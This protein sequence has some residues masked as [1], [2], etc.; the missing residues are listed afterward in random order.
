MIQLQQFAQ[1]LPV[2]TKGLTVTVADVLQGHTL[3]GISQLV[4]K[5]FNTQKP[6]LLQ[7]PKPQQHAQYQKAIQQ[8]GLSE[9]NV[10]AVAPCLSGQVYRLASWLK[11]DATLFEAA[12][13]YSSN[14]ERLDSTRLKEAW[15]RLRQ[16]HSIL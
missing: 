1:R 3:R 4:T 10:E 12:W 13:T 14:G 8:L 15:F 11:S 16:R 7:R 6:E 2:V 5:N 9:E